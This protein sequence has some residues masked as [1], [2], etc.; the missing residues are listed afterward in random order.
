MHKLCICLRGNKSEEMFLRVLKCCCCAEAV[1]CCV[2]GLTRGQ[3]SGLV[4]CAVNQPAISGTCGSSGRQGRQVKLACFVFFEDCN[5]IICKSFPIAVDLWR[6]STCNPDVCTRPNIR[7][8]EI[9]INILWDET[10]NWKAEHELSHQHFLSRAKFPAPGKSFP[11]FWK[12]PESLGGGFTQHTHDTHTHTIFFESVFVITV[13]EVNPF[14]QTLS[15]FQWTPVASQVLMTVKTLQITSINL[16]LLFL[17]HTEHEGTVFSWII[18]CLRGCRTH[19]L[20]AWKGGG[21][22]PSILCLMNAALWRVLR[23]PIVK[24]HCLPACCHGNTLTLAAGLKCCSQSWRKALPEYVRKEK[25]HF[26][27]TPLSE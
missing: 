10:E 13:R 20:L 17:T 8:R 22:I 1:G 26:T 18:R 12:V 23:R 27:L 14:N 4:L 5:K 19:L 6:C 25:P 24:H 7:L 16:Q 21:S 11:S 9:N 2:G 15:A 3:M